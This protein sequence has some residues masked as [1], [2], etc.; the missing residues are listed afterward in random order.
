MVATQALVN[1]AF[2]LL[3]FQYFL[4]IHH[5]LTTTQKQ[6]PEEHADR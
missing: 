1:R 5:S 3:F 4:H 6:S 2:L